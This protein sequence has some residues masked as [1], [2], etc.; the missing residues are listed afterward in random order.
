MRDNF[1]QFGFVE[2][3]SWFKLIGVAEIYVFFW[4]IAALPY[5]LSY[6]NGASSLV[7]SNYNG[8]LCYIM[9]AYFYCRY[10]FSVGLYPLFPIWF[11]FIDPI[12]RFELS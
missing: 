11:C 4:F 3:T 6:F 1:L 10:Y 5:F 8:Y 12:F 9:S 2:A 7:S